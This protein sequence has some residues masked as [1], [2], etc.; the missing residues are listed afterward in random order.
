MSYFGTFYLDK[1]KDIVVE[2]QL[3]EE[4][5]SYTLRTPNHSSGN[6]ITNLAKLVDLP[7]FYDTDNLKILTGE[8]PSFVDG[9]NRTIYIMRL[10]NTKVANIYPDGTIERKAYIPAIAKTLMS[11][12]KNYSLDIKKTLVK[13]YIRSEVKFHSDLHT[14]RSANLSPDILIAMGIHH[15]IQYPYYYVKKLGLRLTQMQRNTIESRRALVATE[16]TDSNLTGKYLDRKIDDHTYMNFADLIL[17]NIEDSTYNIKKIRTSLAVRKDGQ[18][19]FTDLEKVYLYRYVFTKGI[20]SQEKISCNNITKLEDPDI[21]SI[22]L[23][24]E[25]DRTNT[26]YKNN[27]LFQDKLLWTARSYAN[28]GVYYAEISDTAL[29]KKSEAAATLEEIHQVMPAITKETGVT[30]R[31]LAALRRI[32]LTIVKD[33]VNKNNY[34]MENLQVLRAVAID[35]YVAGSDF[36]GEEIN[37]IREL[38]PVI[39]K[40]VEIAKNIPNFVIRIHAGEN[41]SLPDNVLNSI[42]CVEESLGEGQSFPSMRLGHGLYTAKLHTK[43]GQLLLDKLTKYQIPLEFQI[44]SNVRLNNLSEMNAHPLKHYLKHGV[45]CVQGTDG[46]ALYGT[47]SIDEELSLERMLNLTYDDLLQMRQA[48][49]QIIRKSLESFH[50]K[51]IGDVPFVSFYEE[52]IE[53]ETNNYLDV[54]PGE[55]NFDSSYELRER[56]LPLPEGKTPII[57]V[58]GSFNSATHI[59][60][61]H[62]KECHLIDELIANTNPDEVFF[63]IG[64]SMTGYEK[65]LVEKAGSTYDIFCYVPASLTSKELRK[66]QKYDLPIRVSI[67]SSPMGVYKS[68]AFEIFKRRKS[69]LLALDGNSAACNLI[70]DTKNAKY[71]CKRFINARSLGLRP[72]AESLIGYITLWTG[73]NTN[74]ILPEC[75]NLISE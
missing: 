42:L 74:T 25:K 71:L 67:E 29:V 9:Q 35:P 3:R 44:T 32:P 12:T 36:V 1:E 10:G 15:Q 2:L 33:K 37:D 18:A 8:I 30:L 69:I 51:D 28:V 13:T 59:T 39:A 11:Q 20:T 4:Q 64:S 70:Q 57:L 55:R 50:A 46:G 54:A 49:D 56:I 5:M 7:I 58:G 63:V 68:I 23:Q 60:K 19:V 16:Y 14:H 40:I 41:D 65:Y 53:K 47:D 62:D 38:K 6:L 43:K 52:R 21:V 72:K 34:F 31:F 22:L 48:E 17:N 61:L 73:E 75:K 66:I 45:L 26:D 27:T 24:M